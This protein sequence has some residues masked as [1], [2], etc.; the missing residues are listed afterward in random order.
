ML[1]FKATAP[2]ALQSNLFP[3]I[4]IIWLSQ[5]LLA[6]L[7]PTK[8]GRELWPGNFLKSEKNQITSFKQLGKKNILESVLARIQFA[9][10]HT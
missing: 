10:I 6:E 4:S 9:H 1:N 8:S 7:L 2:T 5:S 3:G